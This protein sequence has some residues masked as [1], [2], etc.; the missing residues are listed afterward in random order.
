MYGNL[1]MIET[2]TSDAAHSMGNMELLDQTDQAYNLVV[3][4][5]D[6]LKTMAK[7]G[8]KKCCSSN[9]KLV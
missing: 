4:R 9:Y 8:S 3:R 2:T 7:E 5:N 6:H 1:F